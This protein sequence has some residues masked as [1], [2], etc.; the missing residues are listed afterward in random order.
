M[1][2]YMRHSVSMSN[3]ISQQTH[4]PMIT[5]LLHQNDVVT[6]FCRNNDVIIASCVA[7]LYVCLH[8]N[9]PQQEV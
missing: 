3:A 4:G 6:S 5:S 8:N 1:N 9:A 2:I 7:G